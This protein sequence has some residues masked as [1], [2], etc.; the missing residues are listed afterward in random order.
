M[1]KNAQIQE[2]QE[3]RIRAWRNLALVYLKQQDLEKAEEAIK[4]CLS[5]LKESHNTQDYQKNLASILEVKG[6]IEL[7]KGKPEQA[8]YTWKE[9]EKIYEALNNLTGWIRNIINQVQALQELGLSSQG[10]KSLIEMERILQQQPDTSVK[11][12]ALQVLGDVL[13]EVGQLE[14]SQT[15]LQQSLMLAR[16][17]KLSE[18]VANTLISLGQT[19][20]LKNE[21]DTAS[22]Y[23]QEVIQFSNFPFLKIQG[24]INHFDILVKQDKLTQAIDLIP[25]IEALLTQQ[26]PSID[27][28]NARI[29]L[30]QSLINLRQLESSAIS[31]LN[32]ATQL[33]RV[34][35]EARQ[36]ESQELESYGLGM[37][38]SLYEQNKQWNEAQYLTEKALVLAQAINAPDI[39]YQWQ[40]QLGRIFVIQKKRQEAILAYSQAV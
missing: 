19:A 15:V 8:L 34:I 26:P 1:I 33:K 3:T 40:W 4:I 35:Q 14:R 39:A 30:A 25:E 5:L 38:G 28:V 21:L 20:R 22:S 2:D 9:A 36:L 37:L 31:A 11:V 12:K 23:Y 29:Y 17:L 7:I 16:Q 27:T 10:L 32:I 6:K 13:R 18:E 24:L